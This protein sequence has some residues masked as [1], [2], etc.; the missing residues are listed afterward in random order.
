MLMAAAALAAAPSLNAEPLEKILSSIAS[1]NLELKSLTLSNEASRL[2]RKSENRPGATD[3]EFSWQRGV[4]GTPVTEF[5]LKQEFDFPTLYAARSK[6]SSLRS[7][8]ERLDLDARRRSILSDAAKKCIELSLCHQLDT[9]LSKRAVNRTRFLEGMEESLKL[10]E[11]TRMEYNLLRLEELDLAAEI[12]DNL[13]TARRLEQELTALNGGKPLDLSSI[14]IPEAPQAIPGAEECGEILARSADLLSA[15]ASEEAARQEVSEAKQGWAPSLVAGYRM[16]T[17][18]KDVI[19]GFSVG[20]GFNLFSSSDKVKAARNRQLQASLDRENI[21][22]ATEAE[23][24][25]LIEE[26]QRT[27]QS[28]SL[29]DFPLM[30]ETLELLAF[31]LDQGKMSFT[32]YCME[33]DRIFQRQAE[34]MKLRAKYLLLLADLYK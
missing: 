9:I 20:L 21:R 25:A 12:S 13:A 11:T 28:I 24:K 2:D 26:M 29:Y 14:R 18:G 16:N 7:E 6:T 30:E 27:R 15:E 22:I 5:I 19:P 31:S 1:N 34:Y 23:Q 32:D 17:E 3:A 8:Q 10:G 33:T 4:D